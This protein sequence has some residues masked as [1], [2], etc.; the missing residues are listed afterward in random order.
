MKEASDNAGLAWGAAKLR[1]HLPDHFSLIAGALP[2]QRVAFAILIQ[3][4]VRIQLRRIARQLEYRNLIFSL[5]KP[6]LDLLCSGDRMAI[7]D[8]QHL[9]I[10]ASQKPLEKRDKQQWGEPL[11]KEYGTKRGPVVIVE[12]K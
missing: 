2:A 10:D 11:G 5:R 12:I 6:A 3:V 9:L 4:F 8:Q 1:S 7:H